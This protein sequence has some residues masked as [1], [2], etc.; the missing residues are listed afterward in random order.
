V[1]Y[2]AI[3][4]RLSRHVALVRDAIEVVV[5][6]LSTFPPPPEVEELRAKAEEYLHAADL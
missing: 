1:S 3:V 4:T 6:G 2:H 5:R